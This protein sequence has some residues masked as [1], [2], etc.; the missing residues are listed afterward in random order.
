ME[1][2]TEIE[3]EPVAKARPRYN[4]NGIAYTDKKTKEA[5]K[6]IAYSYINQNGKTLLDGPI[7]VEVNCFYKVPKSYSKKDKEKAKEGRLYKVTRP[8]VDNLAKTVLDALNEVA[9]EDDRLITG[10]KVTKA[11]A[12]DDKEKM[13]IRVRK[14]YE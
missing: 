12:K 6:Y 3:M 11:Y 10:L 8:D 5:E 2:I 14:L 13:I 7:E 1:Y 4:K 9:Y